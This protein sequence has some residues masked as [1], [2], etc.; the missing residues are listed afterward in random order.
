MSDWV[1]DNSP[2][3]K[4]S[5][6]QSD[7]V[8]DSTPMQQ[9]PS[10]QENLKK[11]AFMA[12]PRIGED[13]LNGGV[14]FAKSIPGYLNQ[15]KTE[16]PGM[17][18]VLRQHPIHAAGQATAGLFDLV[19]SLSQLPLNVS[20]YGSDRL[21]LVPPSVTDA[22][23]KYTPDL[24]KD[25][26]AT[27]KLFGQPKYAGEALIRGLTRNLPAIG[28]ATK[29]A[30]AVSPFR[31]AAT[32]PES[33]A[34]SIISSHDAL[35]NRAAQGFEKVA[36][37]VPKRGISTIDMSKNDIDFQN[38]IDSKYLKKSSKELIQKASTGDYNSLRDLQSDLYSEAKK[39]SRSSKSVERHK[40]S[41]MLEDRQKINQAISDHLKDTGNIDL[42]NIL[43][44]SIND[45][46]TL[47]QIYYN[48][49]L[50]RTISRLI[51]PENREVPKNITSVLSTD[52][53]PM[54]KLK[55]YVPDLNDMLS[56]NL[57]RKKTISNIKKYGKSGA[58]VGA[59][60][61][62]GYEGAKHY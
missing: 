31:I 42:S 39:N 30:E 10:Q 36:D 50:N 12:I 33:M 48:P 57:S 43:N 51:D 59:L 60:G 5:S 3:V 22:I 19:N 1:I 28:A 7:W 26:A 52:S 16:V 20:K 45:Y 15:S 46:R 37:E 55:D 47:K 4:N 27:D 54:N 32:S 13:L 17:F 2:E 21:H 29:V 62:G 40:G 56:S 6:P 61:I 8:V 24:Q 53:K 38:M 11:S 25:Q 34:N 9:Q 14:N 35:E 23:N 18:N 49:K 41:D 58:A 44:N